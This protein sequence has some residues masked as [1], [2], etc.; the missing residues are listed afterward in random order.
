MWRKR[1]QQD[2]NAELE[3]HLQLEADQLRSEGLTPKKRK[4]RHGALWEIGRR[5]RSGSTSPRIGCR[6]S[7][8]SATC[9]SPLRV[10]LKDAKFSVLAILGLALGIGV[11]TGIFAVLGPM[12]KPHGSNVRALEEVRNP[13]SYVGLDRGPS[14]NFLLPRVSLLPGAQ[15]SLGRNQRGN[16]SV[17]SCSE[18]NFGGRRR[19]R[20]TGDVR[21][22]ELYFRARNAARAGPKLFQGGGTAWSPACC[23]LELPILAAALRGRRQY[24]RQDHRPERSCGDD[25][26]G[27]GPQIP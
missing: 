27:R 5:R 21:I 13:A 10:L 4:R 22:G 17:Q 24:S 18:S 3:A 15:R 8:S 9:D 25:R 7:I 12:L 26:R 19:G 2:F 6:F 23:H 14:R 11:S 20:R 16:L 1:K